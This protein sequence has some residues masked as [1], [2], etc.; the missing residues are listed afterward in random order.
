MSFFKSLK[1]D[2]ISFSFAYYDGEVDWYSFSSNMSV[3]GNIRDIIT[4][5]AIFLADEYDIEQLYSETEYKSITLELK[6]SENKIFYSVRCENFEEQPDT[7]SDDIRDEEVLEF[8]KEKGIE[9]VRGQFS[10]YGDSGEIHEDIEINGQ[11]EIVRWGGE[12][13]KLLNYLY[14]R[15]EVAFGGWEIDDGSRGEFEIEEHYG[16]TKMITIEQTWQNRVWDDCQ[17]P[18]EITEDMLNE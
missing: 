11:T 18:I 4:G 10:G 3:P 2:S 5:I 12:Y 16:T 7:Y 8:L 17:D 1:K 9:S 6:P 15:L 14:E 13:E